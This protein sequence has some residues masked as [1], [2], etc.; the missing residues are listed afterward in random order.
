MHF[1]L[2]LLFLVLL[3]I[4]VVLSREAVILVAVN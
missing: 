3:F 1:L 4:F 2:F